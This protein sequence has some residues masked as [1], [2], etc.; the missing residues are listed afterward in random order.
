MH[1][2]VLVIHLILALAIIVLVLIQRSSGGGL[3][4]GGGSGGLGDFATA[5]GAANALTKATTIC[6][7]AF[8]A[9]SLTLAY[10]GKG[11]IG[12]GGLLSGYTSESPVAPGAAPAMPGSPADTIT[13]PAKADTPA[14]AKTPEPPISKK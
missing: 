4:I 14:P 9:T 5:R 13:E 2:V 1:E 11:A 7:F 8:F 3:G 12:S 10:M 6:A